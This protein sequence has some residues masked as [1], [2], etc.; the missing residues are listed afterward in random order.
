MLTK[1]SSTNILINASLGK[2]YYIIYYVYAIQY[3]CSE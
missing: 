2:T 3:N 1:S